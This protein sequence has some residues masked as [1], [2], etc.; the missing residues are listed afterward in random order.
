MYNSNTP[1]TMVFSREDFGDDLEQRLLDF[2]LTVT[3][4][5][6]QCR[7][8]RFPGEE[9]LCIGVQFDYY[10]DEINKFSLQWLDDEEYDLV[11]THRRNKKEGISN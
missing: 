9:E 7:V 2:L 1:T 10:D 3:T 5:G 8:Y 4:G 11:M 6:Y